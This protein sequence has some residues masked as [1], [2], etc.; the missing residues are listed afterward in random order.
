[1]KL[2]ARLEAM[3]GAT[4]SYSRLEHIFLVLLLFI[5]SSSLTSLSISWCFLSDTFALITLGSHLQLLFFPSLRFFFSSNVPTLP[6]H[7]HSFSLFAALL[8]LLLLL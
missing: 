5:V 1:M 3:S 2:Q 4:D 6:L 8:S 7:F